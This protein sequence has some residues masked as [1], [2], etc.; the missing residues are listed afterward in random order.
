M[1]TIDDVLFLRKFTGPNSGSV[2]A[3]IAYKG[4]HEV[5]NF[6]DRLSQWQ[7]TEKDLELELGA[8]AEAFAEL[9]R[10]RFPKS[11]L[12]WRDSFYNGRDAERELRHSMVDA[13]LKPEFQE[14]GFYILPGHHISKTFVNQSEDG[15]HPPDA[16]YNVMI[17]M[18]ASVLCP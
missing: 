7:Y 11:A 5:W 10:K 18:I 8:R 4:I 15:V 16:I 12:F 3:V 6:Y 9:L 2:D 13:V 14:Q 17:S 1:L